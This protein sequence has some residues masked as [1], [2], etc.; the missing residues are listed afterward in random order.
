MHYKYTYNTHQGQN[1]RGS[2]NL[3]SLA[4]QRT[5]K[6]EG[7]G[8]NAHQ[9]TLFY[10]FMWESLLFCIISRIWW[11][12][13]ISSLQSFWLSLP[14]WCWWVQEGLGDPIFVSLTILLGSSQIFLHIFKHAKQAKC[15]CIL[16]FPRECH[17]CFLPSHPASGRG[18][19]APCM[20][21][22]TWGYLPRSAI[23]PL[24]SVVACKMLP[25]CLLKCFYGGL[26]SCSPLLH[27]Q[28]VNKSVETS[29]WTKV[30]AAHQSDA[31][32]AGHQGSVS[33][34]SYHQYSFKVTVLT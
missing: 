30:G 13:V 25:P 33:P 11:R 21:C 31:C 19:T 10:G 12:P 7:L 4:V 1:R 32:C 2:K 22:G 6:T 5:R 18:K 8:V 3:V 20:A 14:P 23:S 15:D 16:N 26:A 27:I 29:R 34:A 9:G 17:V 24:G 28:G